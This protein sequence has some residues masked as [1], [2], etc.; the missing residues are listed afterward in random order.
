MGSN[1]D[2]AVLGEKV[3]ERVKE[4]KTRGGKQNP[5]KSKG[6]GPRDCMAWRG[7]TID[8]TDRQSQDGKGKTK[9]EITRNKTRRAP[10]T[11]E[12]EKRFRSQ[13]VGGGI[14]ILESIRPKE[15]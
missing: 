9:S 10:L 2:G 12:E 7:E 14:G 1:R 4:V 11:K 15:V 8:W 3:E 13:G 5:R 6:V